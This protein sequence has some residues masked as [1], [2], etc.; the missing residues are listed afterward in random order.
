M[1]AIE[2][3]LYVIVT[4]KSLR[5]IENPFINP[6]QKYRNSN[7]RGNYTETKN[8]NRYHQNYTIRTIEV[9]LLHKDLVQQ[10]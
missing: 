9:Q 4:K 2:L 8:S 3:I 10:E 7:R 6:I 5:T 1:S